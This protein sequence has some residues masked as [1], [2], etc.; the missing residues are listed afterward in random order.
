MFWEKVVGWMVNSDGAFV[1]ITLVLIFTKR[2]GSQ[3]FYS[4]IQRAQYNIYP[5]KPHTK[6]VVPRHL[7]QAPEL[8]KLVCRTAGSLSTTFFGVYSICC[9]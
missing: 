2:C 4:A 5:S 8:I 3:A 7:L 9:A 6:L 1:Q